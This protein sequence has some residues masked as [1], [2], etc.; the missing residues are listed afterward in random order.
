MDASTAELAQLTLQLEH[1]VD[2]L[3]GIPVGVELVDDNELVQQRIMEAVHTARELR[4][5][6]PVGSTDKGRQ[7]QRSRRRVLDA[8]QR[9]M[10]MRT[11]VHASVL[12]DPGKAARIRELHS[13]GDLHRV[14]DEPIQQLLVFDRAVAFVRT[15]PVAYS[16]G[17]LLIRHPTLITMLVDLFEHMWHKARD[18]TEPVQR[19]TARE[20]E[21]LELIA[22]GRSNSAVARALS[23]TE[24]AVG[25]HVASVFAKLELPATDD[26]NRRVLA[27][28]AYLR[29]TAR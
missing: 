22:E 20:R 25:K 11:I 1:A 7:E 12:D 28:L 14:V 9:G 23:I 5:M 8:L 16:P 24:A 17:A 21:V 19:L 3:R 18:V 29:G 13:S 15:T 27:V 26:V 6:H 4:A 10:E 2:K